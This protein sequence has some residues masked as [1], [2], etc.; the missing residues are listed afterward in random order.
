MGS[1]GSIEKVMV[2][3]ILGIILLILVVAVRGSADDSASGKEDGVRLTGNPAALVN[4]AG[5]SDLTD[6]AIASKRGEPTAA[7]DPQQLKV[8]QPAILRESGREAGDDSVDMTAPIRPTAA[9]RPDIP[10]PTGPAAQRTYQI[11]AGDTLEKV[12][13]DQLGNRDFLAEL[14]KVNED[15]NERKLRVGQIINLP[16]VS[17]LP[18]PSGTAAPGREPETAGTSG[19]SHTVAGGETLI[20]I[21]RKYYNDVGRWE[22]I[23]QANADVLKDPKGLR[24]GMVLRIP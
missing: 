21:A 18:V 9:R 2:G 1:V 8:D 10:A 17:N 15:V 13:V 3:G 5:D 22:Q 20:A 4:G 6:P 24:P 19:R 16:D 23:L 14:R 11:K 7:I 12:A